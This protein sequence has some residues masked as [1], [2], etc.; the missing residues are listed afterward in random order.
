MIG[1]AIID[2]HD[3]EFG[4]FQTGCWSMVP[5]IIEGIKAVGSF[6]AFGGDRTIDDSNLCRLCRKH[7]GQGMMIIAREI[8]EFSKLPGI[9]FLMEVTVAAQ[10]AECHAA[11]QELDG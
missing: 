8:K 5:G 4:K 3:G 6:S 10:I 2:I 9:G 11:A 7:G 1:R